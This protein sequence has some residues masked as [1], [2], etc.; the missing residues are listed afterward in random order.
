MWHVFFSLLSRSRQV[1]H[2]ECLH[3][4]TT[5]SIGWTKQILHVMESCCEFSTC[6][7]AAAC[8]SGAGTSSGTSS[9]TSLSL[10]ESTSSPPFILLLR[11]AIAFTKW[12]LSLQPTKEDSLV[13]QNLLI[14]ILIHYLILNFSIQLQLQFYFTLTSTTILFY[15]ILFIRFSILVWW[16]D[17][18]WVFQPWFSQPG[19]ILFQVSYFQSY[20]I[21]SKFFPS[22]YSQPAEWHSLDN[23]E[24]LFR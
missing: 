4:S 19:S 3:R 1:L 9:S 13:R 5:V 14:R 6:G 18:P 16:F 23:L 11:W 24:T 12:K 10:S 8:G 17:F 2:P 7:S 21:P 20:F 22:C 15:P